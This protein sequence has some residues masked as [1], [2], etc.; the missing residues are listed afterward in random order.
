MEP[1]SLGDGAFFEITDSGIFINDRET[2]DNVTL[3]SSQL[4]ALYLGLHSLLG[5][6]EVE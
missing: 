1:I 3:S 6:D 5:S 2:G 4:E